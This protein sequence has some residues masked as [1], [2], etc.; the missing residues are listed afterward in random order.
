MSESNISNTIFWLFTARSLTDTSNP[1]VT[2]RQQL[3]AKVD[4]ACQQWRD[5]LWMECGR[6]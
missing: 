4:M 1:G 6:I 2:V 3:G 5:V